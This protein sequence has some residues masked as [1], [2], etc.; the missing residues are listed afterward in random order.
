[1]PPLTVFPAES[2]FERSVGIAAHGG[3][4]LEIQPVKWS[5]TWRRFLLS[6]PKRNNQLEHATASMLLGPA[7]PCSRAATGSMVSSDISRFWM[8][9]MDENWGMSSNKGS[10][11][12]GCLFFNNC[13]IGRPL[14]PHVSLGTSLL[15]PLQEVINCVYYKLFVIIIV[16]KHYPIKILQT[17]K[18][19]LKTLQHI[20]TNDNFILNTILIW[21]AFIIHF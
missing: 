18:F 16:C 7:L 1:M 12:Y 11:R 14:L 9:G 3:M 6:G 19:P 2:L 10:L 5:I 21:T 17:L 13:D 15:P 20:T 8:V 4:L